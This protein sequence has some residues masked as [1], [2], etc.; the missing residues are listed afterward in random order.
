MQVVL[1]AA[2]LEVRLQPAAHHEPGGLIDGD[3]SLV[4]QAVDVGPERQSVFHVVLPALRVGLDVRRLEAGIEGAGYLCYG[5]L[6]NGNT[7]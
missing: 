5:H 7:N 4:E 2:V 1:G 6:R 3:V